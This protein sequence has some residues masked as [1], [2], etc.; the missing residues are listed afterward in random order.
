MDSTHRGMIYSFGRPCKYLMESSHTARHSA[1]GIRATESV[2]LP[3]IDGRSRKKMSIQLNSVVAQV[4]D[5][6]FY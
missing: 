4:F 2:A 6:S 1:H 3:I 5:E